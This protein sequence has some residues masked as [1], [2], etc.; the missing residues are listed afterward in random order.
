M[1][2]PRTNEQGEPL[3]AD[4]DGV[5]D[6]VLGGSIGGWDYTRA[7][8]ERARRESEPFQRLM[9]ETIERANPPITIELTEYGQ[10]L[11]D[12]MRRAWARRWLNLDAPISPELA[13]VLAACAD[14]IDSAAPEPGGDVDVERPRQEHPIAALLRG[15]AGR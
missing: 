12:E 5:I 14:K 7:D 4:A 2:W 8:I 1:T 3:T 13:E 15:L 11:T 9:R 10:P 6:S